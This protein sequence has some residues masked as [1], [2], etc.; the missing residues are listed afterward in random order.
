MRD[1]SFDLFEPNKEGHLKFIGRCLCVS[2]YLCMD[3]MYPG[4]PPAQ[5]VK[6]NKEKI[7]ERI[8]EEVS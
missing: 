3:R 8:A 4:A 1:D 7:A 5:S 2:E 6:I